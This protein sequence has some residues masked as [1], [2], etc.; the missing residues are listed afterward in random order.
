MDKMSIDIKKIRRE[1]NDKTLKLDL[2]IDKS[3]KINEFNK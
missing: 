3:E 2:M 1:K